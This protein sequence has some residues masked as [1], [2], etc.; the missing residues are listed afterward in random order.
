[1]ELG[2]KNFIVVYF[3]FYL[4]FLSQTSSLRFIIYARS[5]TFKHL[6]SD[7]H[8][9]WLSSVLIIAVQVITTLLLDNII[10]LLESTIWLNAN[11]VLIIDFYVRLYYNQFTQTSGGFEIASTIIVLLQRKRLTTLASDPRATHRCVWK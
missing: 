2:C 3:F 5:P 10:P 9:R 8:L 11:F 4:V 1:M 6:L 7:L